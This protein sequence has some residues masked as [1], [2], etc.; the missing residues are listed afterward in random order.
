MSFTNYFKIFNFLK[1]FKKNYILR[2]FEQIIYLVFFIY[3]IKLIYFIPPYSYIITISFSF[4]LLETI[5]ILP[6]F[7]NK[8]ITKT[9][10]INYFFCIVVIIFKGLQETFYSEGFLN[11]I[12]YINSWFILNNGIIIDFQFNQTT[13][14]FFGVILVSLSSICILLFSIEYLFFF[15]VIKF[16]QFMI[17]FVIFML[18]N[19][20]AND[21]I[22]TFIGWEGIGLM[23]FILINFWKTRHEANKA[24]LKAFLVNKIGD[25]AFF[26]IIIIV[27]LTSYNSSFQSLILFFL[28]STTFELKVIS[29]VFIFVVLSKSAQFFLH[30]WLDDAMEGPTPVSALIHAATL[31]TAGSFLFVKISLLFSQPFFLN[32]VLILGIFSSLIGVLSSLEQDDLKKTVAYT[33]LTNIGLIFIFFGLGFF[34]LG[35]FH[36]ITHGFYKAFTF[37]AVGNFIH[38]TSGEQSVKFKGLSAK[39]FSLDYFFLLFSS[40]SMIGFPFLGAFYSK[41]VL[42][43]LYNYSSNLFLIVSISIIWFLGIISN[44]SILSIFL[45]NLPPRNINILFSVFHK[46]KIFIDLVLLILGILVLVVPI[47]IYNFFYNFEFSLNTGISSLNQYLNQQD[48][49]INSFLYINHNELYLNLVQ[50]SSFLFVP[51]I[52]NSNLKINF[53]N[54]AIGDFIILGIVVIIGKFSKKISKLFYNIFILNEY[55]IIEFIYFYFIKYLFQNYSNSFKNLNKSI[56]YLTLALFISLYFSIL[57][58]FFF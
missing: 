9:L 17:I 32:I 30:F 6:F 21:L 19:I 14:T 56:F 37:L 24:A 22:L 26:L 20:L 4:L 51:L 15:E 33:T 23:S 45:L 34:H 58:Y 43:T 29:I 41:E 5:F 55:I 16:L 11:I 28:L 42:F 57:I 49:F 1:I 53:L 3:L 8:E 39:I 25:F 7:N 38:I 2:I 48:L 47:I 50:I 31:V 40:F 18:L 12:T 27:L 36:L 35:F 13:Y 10:V 54:N 52:L 46:N 44:F